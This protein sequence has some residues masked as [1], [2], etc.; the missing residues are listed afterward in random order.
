MSCHPSTSLMPIS[1]ML[2]ITEV[3]LLFTYASGKNFSYPLKLSYHHILTV[4]HLEPFS[5]QSLPC[6]PAT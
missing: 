1:S 6:I 2:F 5:H 3:D 4:L